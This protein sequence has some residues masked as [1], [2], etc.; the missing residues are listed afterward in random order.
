MD[1]IESF[2]Q[3]EGYPPTLE[4]LCALLFLNSKGGLHTTLN[5]MR[6]GGFIDWQ[7]GKNRTIHVVRDEVAE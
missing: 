3:S 6:Q 5:R 2:T 7:D 4:E 1:L